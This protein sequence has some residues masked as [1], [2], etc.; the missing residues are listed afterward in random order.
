MPA[1]PRQF[2]IRVATFVL[3]LGVATFV[4]DAALT[5][6]AIRGIRIVPKIPAPEYLRLLDAEDRVL[7]L[8]DS[9]MLYAPE[10]ESNRRSLVARLG[11]EF[12]V[13]IENATRA[14]RGTEMARAQI[15]ALVRLGV[16]PR[17]VVVE[18]SLR[19]FS[20]LWEGNPNLEDPSLERMLLTGSFLPLRAAGVFKYEFGRITPR[21]Y[22]AKPVFVAGTPVGT[23]GD[24]EHKGAG[25][26]RAGPLDSGIVGDRCRLAY[27]FDL[28]RSTRLSML[29]ELFAT[30]RAADIP[31]VAFVTPLDMEFIASHCA[32]ADVERV[33]QNLAALGGEITQP[34]VFAA[35]LSQTLSLADFDHPADWPDE[36]LRFAG[37]EFVAKQ[38]GALVR[39]ALGER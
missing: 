15:A 12:A 38:V 30:L 25:I 7:V 23:V 27:A 13:A 17:A 22:R 18:V 19:Q 21:E 8:G 2:A 29:R 26:G 24:L 9:V 33:R 39:Q 11:D 32:P 14:G 28:D 35:D 5:R 6:L 36:H 16:R 20:P 3:V 4:A 34:G 31:C 37:R 10:G 1:T